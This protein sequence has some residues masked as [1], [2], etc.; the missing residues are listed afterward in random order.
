MFIRYPLGAIY[1]TGEYILQNS[2]LHPISSRIT[3]T[4]IEVLQ[5]GKRNNCDQNNEGSCFEKKYTEGINDEYIK[6]KIVGDNDST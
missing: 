1:T 6:D 2:S 4:L 5:K 3:K